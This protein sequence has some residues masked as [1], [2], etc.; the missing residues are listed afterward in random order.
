[1]GKAAARSLY[2]LDWKS[3]FIV[4]VA[5]KTESRFDEIF[6]KRQIPPQSYLFLQAAGT[7]KPKHFI[8]S[9]SWL[10]PPSA[11]IRNSLAMTYHPLHPL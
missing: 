3:K 5:I 9:L 10:Y 2:T 6:P 1:V 8:H 7:A 4:L 11:N